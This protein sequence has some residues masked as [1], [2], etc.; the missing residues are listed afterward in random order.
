[1]SEQFLQGDGTVGYK[2]SAAQLQW[3]GKYSTLAEALGK[4]AE[5]YK[6]NDSGKHEAAQMLE[7]ERT[8]NGA[9]PTSTPT[10]APGRSSSGGASGSSSGASYVSNITING[11]RR[12]VGFADRQSQLDGEA[13]IRMLAEGK[14]VA[15]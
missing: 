6:Y 5:Y 15:Q 14:G 13:L 7:Y 10:S 11:Q 3:G 4:M 12:T 2:A 1:M 9:R 8:K